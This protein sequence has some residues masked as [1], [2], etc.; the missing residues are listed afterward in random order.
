MKGPQLQAMELF[1]HSQSFCVGGR[2]FSDC[3]LILEKCLAFFSLTHVISQTTTIVGDQFYVRRL[4]E[5][6]LW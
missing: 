2:V 1:K 5:D 3:F 6:V 4:L